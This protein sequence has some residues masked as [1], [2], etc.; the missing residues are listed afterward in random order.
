MNVPEDWYLME[1]NLYQLPHLKLLNCLMEYFT[2][3]LKF[4]IK[5]F[6][7]SPLTCCQSFLIKSTMHNLEW[8]SGSV[9]LS[10]H[11]VR[12]YNSNLLV[13]NVFPERNETSPKI[14]EL[15]KNCIQSIFINHVRESIVDGYRDTCVNSGKLPLL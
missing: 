5:Y 9:V 6:V 7:S 8:T 15:A 10:N 13:D 3:Q 11:P 14:L 2:G 12:F 1:L 4:K